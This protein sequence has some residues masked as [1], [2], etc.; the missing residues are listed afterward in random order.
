MAKDENFPMLDFEKKVKES[1]NGQLTSLENLIELGE[2]CSQIIEILLIA[3]M[4]RN[5]LK[6]YGS[7]AEMKKSCQ[8][9]IELIDSSFW[10]LT[11]KDE[12][13]LLN[14]SRKF[15]LVL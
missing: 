9:S 4:D 1:K 7:D 14:L 5:K 11:S 2:A 10:E 3:D 15:D 12:K 13:F 6:R 8:Y